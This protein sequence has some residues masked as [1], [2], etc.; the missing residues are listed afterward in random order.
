MTVIIY[1]ERLCNGAA[2]H[3]VETQRELRSIT[4]RVEAKANGN[5]ARAR[6]TG[7]EKISGPEHV[8]EIDA[9]SSTGKYGAVDYEVSMTGT[10]PMAIEF[11][12]APSGAFD[13]EKVGFVSKAPHGL[14]ILTRAA[15]IGGYTGMPGGRS[16]K[17]TYK[18]RNRGK[19]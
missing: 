9:H 12:H 1:G 4:K 15:G 18:G 11:G 8:T 7:V 2:A 10:N 17:K 19:R 6:A 13:P 5:L 14:Y 16:R 3:H